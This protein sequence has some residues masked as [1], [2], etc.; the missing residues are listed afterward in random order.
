MKQIL[1]TRLFLEKILLIRTFLPKYTLL[2]PQR[3]FER[4][5]QEFDT[6]LF[7]KFEFGIKFHTVAINEL[8]CM[9]NAGAQIVMDFS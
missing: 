7:K 3:L 2:G 1:P 8:L 4:S 5:G 6:Y 9:K